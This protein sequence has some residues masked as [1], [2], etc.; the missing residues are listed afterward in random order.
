MKFGTYAKRMVKLIQRTY[1]SE[2]IPVRTLNCC[3]HK[4]KIIV[5]EDYCSLRSISAPILFQYDH[6]VSIDYTAFW[7]FLPLPPMHNSGSWFAH[8]IMVT[9]P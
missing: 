6:V 2:N 4:L 7:F 5:C 1:T 9:V 3:D 8:N